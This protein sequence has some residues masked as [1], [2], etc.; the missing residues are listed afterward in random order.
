MTIKE[1]KNTYKNMIKEFDEA[2]KRRRKY[3]KETM[4]EH[5]EHRKEED[6]IT[7]KSVKYRKKIAS[8]MYRSLMDK[9]NTAMKKGWKYDEK[10][11]TW[12]C[13]GCKR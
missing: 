5:I 7:Q 12:Y 4:K 6:K 13:N 8:G 1:L 10:S 3:L 11:D 9:E 2:Y